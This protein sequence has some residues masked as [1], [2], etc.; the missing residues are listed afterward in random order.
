MVHRAAK[1]DRKVFWR[2]KNGIFYTCRLLASLTVVTHYDIPRDSL[3]EPLL[4]VM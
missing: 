2:G 3:H 1:R 4:R